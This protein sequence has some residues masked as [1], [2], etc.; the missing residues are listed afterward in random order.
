MN[1]VSVCLHSSTRD[2]AADFVPL[3]HSCPRD[4][5]TNKHTSFIVCCSV[6][7]C[8]SRIAIHTVLYSSSR[9]TC[10]NKFERRPRRNLHHRIT[11]GHWLRAIIQQLLTCCRVCECEKVCDGGVYL[12]PTNNTTISTTRTHT[13][14]LF[15]LALRHRQ[16]L[17]GVDQLA[18]PFIYQQEALIR[19][20][21]LCLSL[22]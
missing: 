15:R 21:I 19:A 1:Y 6:A 3:I 10:T 7:G 2:T 22:T 8:Q 14:V 11:T 9:S 18:S 17:S 16:P 13:R 5:Y 20:H 12:L 4:G